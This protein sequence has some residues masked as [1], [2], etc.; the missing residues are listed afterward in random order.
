MKK[1][2]K[3]AINIAEIHIRKRYFIFNELYTVLKHPHFND[4]N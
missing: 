2:E 3:I 4:E 1:R